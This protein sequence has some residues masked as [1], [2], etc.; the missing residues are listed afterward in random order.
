MNK[1]KYRSVASNDSDGISILLS[2][3]G[4]K[5]DPEEIIYRLNELN[6]QS[7][8]FV[9]EQNTKLVGVVQTQI[10]TRL[11]EG[12]YGEI[13]ALVVKEECRG[14]GIGKKLL[15]LAIE[16]MRNLG[17]KSYVVRTNSKRKNAHQFYISQGFKEIKTQKIFKLVD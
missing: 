17:C 7:V 2:E 13:T 1:T 9:A 6:L 4:Y 3:L 14:T 11:A 5:V 15:L 10:N 8:I 16:N 12:K